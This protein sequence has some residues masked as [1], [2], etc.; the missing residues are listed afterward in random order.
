MLAVC[1]Y[2]TIF[3]QCSSGFIFPF[4]ANPAIA[5]L[6]VLFPFLASDQPRPGLN[7]PT[8]ISKLH[9]L[10]EEEL[11]TAFNKG[12]SYLI[13]GQFEDALYEFN[14]AADISP[15]TGDIFLSRGIVKEKLL[16]WNEAIDDYK[17]ANQLF[18]SKPFASDDPTVFSNIANAE[19]G[20]LEWQNAYRDFS[21]AIK[22]KSD[23][24]AP[25]I[26]LAM[27]QY[28]LGQVAQAR[29]YFESLA[30]DYPDFPDG[31]ALLAVALF[32]DDSGVNVDGDSPQVHWAKAVELDPRYSD[33]EWLRD[34]RRWTPKLVDDAAALLKALTT[35]E[36]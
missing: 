36:R 14:H 29:E 2:L 26:G 11:I 33:L 31:Q 3:T 9:P 4:I 12:N 32:H 7:I 23:F 27:V 13:S 1:L 30:D 19:T 20:L 17:K 8:A 6:P 24:I 18:R 21:Y 34:I 22:L 5:F 16:R 25:R 15:T 10:P 35:S 28:Q